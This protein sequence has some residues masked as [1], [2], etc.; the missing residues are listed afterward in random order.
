M[1]TEQM[2]QKCFC[3]DHC[4]SQ[5]RCNRC[6]ADNWQSIARAVRRFVKMENKQAMERAL[7][8]AG[9]IDKETK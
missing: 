9:K 8:V 3:E 1:T 7:K 2:V 5:C 6:H 4:P